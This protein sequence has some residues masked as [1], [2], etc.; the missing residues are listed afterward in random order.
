MKGSFAK[1]R[2]LYVPV[3][4]IGGEGRLLRACR[5]LNL[6]FHCLTASLG[7]HGENKEGKV[8]VQRKKKIKVF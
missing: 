6:S 8:Y 5:I 7:V 1:A 3:E 2:V 4:E